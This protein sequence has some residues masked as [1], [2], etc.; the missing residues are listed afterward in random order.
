[1]ARGGDGPQRQRAGHGRLQVH[2]VGH[3]T[4]GPID[5]EHRAEVNPTSGPFHHANR[6]NRASPRHLIT[7]YGAAHATRRQNQTPRLPRVND[8]K[9]PLRTTRSGR[10]PS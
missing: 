3:H 1:V 7:K 9:R 8:G 2:S 6:E 10:L 5:P 4:A